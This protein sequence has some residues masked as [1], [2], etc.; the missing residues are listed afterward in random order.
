M[1]FIPIINIIVMIYACNLVRDEYEHECY[2]VNI[3]KTRVDSAICKTKYPSVLIHGVGF[4]DFKYINYWGRIPKELIRQGAT[5][6]Y[7]NQE[8]FGAVEY[9]A[10]DI[11]EMIINRLM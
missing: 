1:V 8:A 9:N 5:V 4:R 3:E 7:V 11:K 2:K 10:K 6:Y